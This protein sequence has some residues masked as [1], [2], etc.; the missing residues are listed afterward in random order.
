M[1]TPST[2]AYNTSPGIGPGQVITTTIIRQT[3]LIVLLI[4]SPPAIA[5]NTL[6]TRTYGGTW[7]DGAHDVAKTSDGGLVVT[8]FN[9][10]SSTNHLKDILLM[11]TDALGNELWSRTF[12]GFLNDIGTSVR[13]TQDGGYIITGMTEVAPQLR[14]DD[15]IET[16]RM[17]LLK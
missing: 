15:G 10:S 4:A 5:Q 12:G 11:K 8:G 16:R 17:L 6:W 3:V 1:R 7:Q 13:Q 14:T 2:P 9:S